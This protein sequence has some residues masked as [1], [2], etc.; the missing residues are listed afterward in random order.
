MNASS[1]WCVG[2]VIEAAG[3]GTGKLRLLDFGA[4]L[5]AFA[6]SYFIASRMYADAVSMSHTTTAITTMIQPTSC[7]IACPLY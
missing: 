2:Q 6:H 1:R 4:M 7:H 3:K 5:V